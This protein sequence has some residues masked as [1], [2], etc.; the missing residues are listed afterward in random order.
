[1]YCL[2]STHITP[3]QCSA[4]FPLV[5]AL[6]HSCSILFSFGYY[7]DITITVFLLIDYPYNFRLLC[8]SELPLR[9][10][11]SSYSYRRTPS[12]TYILQILF[13]RCV[14]I[15]EP[16]IDMT[17]SSFYTVLSIITTAVVCHQVI[18]YTIPSLFRTVQSWFHG[19]I[20]ELL[21]ILVSS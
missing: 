4:T 1:M 9:Q 15:V 21:L 7:V 13:F 14:G 19:I 16:F 2:S 5:Y 10:Y 12:Q 8:S 20:R 11:T 6:F 3:S 18:T 17:F